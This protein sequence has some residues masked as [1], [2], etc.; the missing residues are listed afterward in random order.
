VLGSLRV[1]RPWERGRS[2]DDTSAA[3]V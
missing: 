3:A 2:G 1:A